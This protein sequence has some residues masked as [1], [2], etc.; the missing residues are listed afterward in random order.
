MKK[1]L[2]TAFLMAAMA[3]TAAKSRPPIPPWPGPTQKPPKTPIDCRV[4]PR[5]CLPP[6]A[7][8]K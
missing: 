1:L 5:P 4:Q 3:A 2:V 7:P 8:G 6:I